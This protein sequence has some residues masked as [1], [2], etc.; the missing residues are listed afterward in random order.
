VLLHSQKKALAVA[1]LKAM[2]SVAQLHALLGGCH[3]RL[4]GIVSSTFEAAVLL[5]YLLMDPMFP[6]NCPHAQSAQQNT[7]PKTDPLQA[8][9]R[10]VTRPGCL[11]AVQGAL[12]RLKMLAEVSS[13]A[14][15][16]ANI[17]IQVLSKASETGGGRVTGTGTNETTPIQNQEVG[18]TT[19]ITAGP[20]L[21]K[22]SGASELAHWLTGS[23]QLDF[24]SISGIPAIGDMALW[25]FLD[26][27]TIYQQ[28]TEYLDET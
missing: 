26:P 5:L 2:D 25:P 11:Q 7:P 16:A 4:V 28:D 21:G 12:K 20:P 8:G 17:L 15:V 27:A 23:D 19:R 22:I 18:N 10:K 1:A 14:D 13:L 3:T 24:T 6:E 9:M